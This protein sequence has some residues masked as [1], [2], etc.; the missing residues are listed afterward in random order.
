VALI[1]TLIPILLLAALSQSGTVYLN[2]L[3]T[4]DIHGGIVERD[5]TF[6]NPDF[7]PAVGGGDGSHH[8]F[9]KPADTAKMPVNSW[10]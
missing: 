3:H 10:F 1:R 4:N 8:S 7:P 2:I 6:L 5:A 9:S